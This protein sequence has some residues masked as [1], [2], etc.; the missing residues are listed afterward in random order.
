MIRTRR[1]LLGIGILVMAAVFM[2][3][4]T[5]E[6]TRADTGELEQIRHEIKAKGAKWHA[7]DTS[8]SRLS[9]KEKRMRLG[10][11]DDGDLAAIMG[12]TSESVPL[13]TLEGAPTTLD[14]RNVGG[15]TYVSPIKNQ[16]SCGSCWAFAV[17]AGLESQAMIGTSG[18]QVDLS[19][20]ILVS[21]SGAG[22]CSGGYTASA[23]NYIRDYGLPVE[24]C[25][26][27]TAT[28]NACSNACADWQTG[29]AT[30]YSVK[31]WHTATTLTYPERVEGIKNALY[32][33]GPVI[34]SFYVYNDFYSYRS[35]VYSYTTGSYVGAHAVLIV[36]YDDTL[37]AFIVKNSWGTGWGEAGYFMIAYSEVGGTSRF[38]Y[39]VI[40]YD[41]YGDNPSPTPDPV[42]D[43]PAPTTCTYALSPTSKN[44]KPAGGTGS[45]TVSTQ[46][47]CPWTAATTASWVTITSGSSGTA[48]STTGYM[49]AANT[50][51]ARTATIT[52]QGLEYKVYQQK[53]RVK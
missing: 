6:F 52:I 22:S 41:G 50:G 16:G 7:D 53:A 11:K 12:D 36:G 35:G 3:V 51:A 48:A 49:V 21:C 14:W 38:G 27:Y 30:L 43:P 46:S 26:A 2:L 18:T 42:P 31:G 4:I 44:F 13:A 23:S 29:Q 1:R 39:S 34:A 9:V 8:V 28:N 32:T 40:A 5:S 24:S 25:F 19:E 45:F 20:Q 47:G 15:I 10:H 37:Q 33:Y 17:T